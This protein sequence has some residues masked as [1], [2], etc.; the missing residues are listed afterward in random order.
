ML[1]KKIYVAIMLIIIGFITALEGNLGAFSIDDIKDF[2]F[3]DIT[4][5]SFGQ[6]FFICFGLLFSIISLVL[7]VKQYI[8]NSRLKNN[9]IETQGFVKRI[10]K[11]DWG[12]DDDGFNKYKFKIFI[13]FRD[14][15][16]MAHEALLVHIERTTSYKEGDN[17]QIKYNRDNP[18]DYLVGSITAIEWVMYLIF[19][20]VGLIFAVIGYKVL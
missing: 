14:Y 9:G 16:G 17:I 5:D 20:I 1:M 10:E 11:I 13:D 2:K 8:K 7:F 3:G 19:I 4:I 18:N 6:I 15:R 12:R